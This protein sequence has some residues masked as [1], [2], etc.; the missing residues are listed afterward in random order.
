MMAHRDCDPTSTGVSCLRHRW[1]VP[2]GEASCK[3]IKHAH[4]LRIRK[5]AADNW[6]HA[7]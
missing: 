5:T 3:A 4:A 2:A 1:L 7:G 6:A